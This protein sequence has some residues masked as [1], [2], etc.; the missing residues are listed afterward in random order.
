MIPEMAEYLNPGKKHHY[1]NAERLYYLITK[2]LLT[3][4]RNWVLTI[5]GIC[6]IV[7]FVFCDF[8]PTEL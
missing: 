6:I 3:I 4:S 2:R 8:M 7:H 1:I 5:P